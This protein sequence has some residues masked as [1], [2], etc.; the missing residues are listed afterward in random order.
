MAGEKNFENKIK[1]YLE[2]EGTWFVKFFANRMTKIGIPDLLC[3]VN[4]FFLAVEVKAEKGKPSELQVWNRDRIVRSGG[5]AVI[6]YP[7]Q[8]DTFTL[9][10]RALKENL[11]GEAMHHMDQINSKIVL[12]CS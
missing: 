7:D 5:F 6:L 4:G 9:L 1:K 10:V 11:A 3:C 12:N 8:F 2:S